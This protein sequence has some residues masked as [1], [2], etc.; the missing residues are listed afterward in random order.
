[1]ATLLGWPGSKDHVRWTL[2]WRGPDTRSYLSMLLSCRRLSWRRRKT[3][4]CHTPLKSKGLQS[5]VLGCS[6]PWAH[7]VVSMVGLIALTNDG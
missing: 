1:M 6:V 5:T 7:V 4:C 2:E 3:P